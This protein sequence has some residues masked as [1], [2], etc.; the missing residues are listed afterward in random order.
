[1]GS[2]CASKV[3]PPQERKGS[4]G[5]A[6]AQQPEKGG[7]DGRDGPHAADGASGQQGESADADV[8]ADLDI[9]ASAIDA[10]GG[11][12][13]DTLE[14]PEPQLP[15]GRECSTPRPFCDEA[16]GVCVA[17]LQEADCSEP[18]TPY[19]IEHRCVSCR[20]SAD[21][22]DA[23][24]AR[25]DDESHMCVG[26]Q[27]SADCENIMDGEVPLSVC[28][29]EDHR[30]VQ[31][32]GL[33]SQACGLHEDGKTPLV[34]DSKARTCTVRRAGL[35]L[36]C[37]SCVSDAECSTGL[38]CVQETVN[39]L[40]LGF[41]CQFVLGE[42]PL[43]SSCK[44]EDAGPY[45]A[46]RPQIS[47]IDGSQVSACGLRRST[48]AATQ[49]FPEGTP[50]T[51]VGSFAECGVEGVEDAICVPTDPVTPTESLFCAPL[52]SNSDD[53]TFDHA[54]V[55]TAEPRRY[56][57]P[58]PANCYAD[59]DCEEGLRCESLTCVPL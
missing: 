40:T 18:A 43:L 11:S 48:C 29:P 36:A 54:C 15:C 22:A 57:D 4:I 13:D 17:C 34:C 59:T 33:N 20:T 23:A 41:V 7:G 30:C 26:C 42:P 52:C 39:G 6:P 47:T 27:D 3:P 1:M 37:A 31:C 55:T 50:C 38:K 19:C 56:C 8:D 5:T 53:C 10:G 21:C 45:R 16:S 28:A 51:E 49:S 12:M 32:T 2:G 25:C 58:N 24:A 9:S 44:G 46:D 14:A 35:L